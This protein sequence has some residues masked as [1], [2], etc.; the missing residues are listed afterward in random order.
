MRW[1]MLF[2]VLLIGGCGEGYHLPQAITRL[3]SRSVTDMAA[4]SKAVSSKLVELGFE[5]HADDAFPDY[6]LERL[7]TA[8]RWQTTQT[9]NFSRTGRAFSPVATLLVHITPYPDA[10][11]PHISSSKAV[12]VE[13]RPPFI[14][15]RIAEGRRDGFSAE[16]IAAHAEIARV[17]ER[18]A[19]KIIVVSAPVR[20][21]D[22]DYFASQTKD[23][24]L[25]IT[26]WLAT[27][28]ISMTIIGGLTMLGLRRLGASTLF[29]RAALIGVGTLFV[30]PVP[31]P[32]MFVQL[33][34]PSL[35]VIWSPGDLIL[36]FQHY[37]APLLI[38][39][40]LSLVL[41]VLTAWINVRDRPR[42]SSAN[43]MSS[44]A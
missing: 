27:W 25:A 6:M 41:S 28:A 12:N 10:G 16:G 21:N 29:R 17:L 22:R 5:H 33:L 13:T 14:E 26:W 42:R 1:L 39:F 34:I 40:A 44:E 7:D 19:G 43:R 11:V 24:L 30:T 23:L 18:H 4:A 3:E 2:V 15:V 9:M 8:T 32:T 36:L 31:A 20:G 37:G 35:F 38:T